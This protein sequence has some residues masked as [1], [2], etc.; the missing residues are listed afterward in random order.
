MVQFYRCFFKNFAFYHGTNHQVDEK[1]RTLYLD[2][3]MSR[4]LGLDQAK[5]HGSTDLILPNQ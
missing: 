1:N 4:R 3:K 5:I 2:H